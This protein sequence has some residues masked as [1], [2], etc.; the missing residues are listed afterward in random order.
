MASSDTFWTCA[1]DLDLKT[2]LFFQGLA[3]LC[4]ATVSI[5]RRNRHTSRHSEGG[6]LRLLIA[7][8]K[9]QCKSSHDVLL[10]HG[11][12]KKQQLKRFVCKGEENDGGERA[13]SMG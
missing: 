7:A 11:R 6:D 5:T 13:S 8:E 9:V 1:F 10:T 2:N 12:T 4:R 3:A